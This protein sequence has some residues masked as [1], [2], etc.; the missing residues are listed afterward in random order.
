MDK[1]GVVYMYDRILVIKKNEISP[2]VTTWMNLEG[3]MLSELYQAD[4]DSYSMISFMESKQ[5]N[6]WTNKTKQKWTHRELTTENSLVVARGAGGEGQV[7]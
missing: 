1:D 7:K 6:K 2:S 4:K 3:I 5:Q